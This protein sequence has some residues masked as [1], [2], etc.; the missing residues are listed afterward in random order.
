[1]KP[2]LPLTLAVALSTASAGLAYNAPLTTTSTAV[3]GSSSIGNGQTY[4]GV[5]Y[6]Y[7]SGSLFASA[8]FSQYINAD[9]TM[10]DGATTLGTADVTVD[11]K[12]HALWYLYCDNAN[13]TRGH[14]LRFKASATA[15]SS[16]MKFSPETLGGLIVENAENIQGASNVKL[17]SGGN[18]RQLYIGGAESTGV[19]FTIGA[20][21]EL[22][23]ANIALTSASNK[24]QVS[25]GKTLKFTAS[26]SVTFAADSTTTVSSGGTVD[27][28]TSHALTGSNSRIVL[29]DASTLSNVTLGNGMIISTDTNA[30]GTLNNLTLNG[31]TI[32]FG[33]LSGTV[34]GLSYTGTLTLT[35]GD[36][37]IAGIDST[38]LS[39]GSIYTLLS[40]TGGSGSLTGLTINGAEIAENGSFTMTADSKR[41][42]GSL[43]WS[44]GN[45]QLQDLTL[46]SR[47]LTW[48]GGAT[49]VWSAS[50]SVTG[51]NLD[52]AAGGASSFADGDT[53]NISG[54]ASVVLTVEGSVDP[55]GM[56]ISG[57]AN[58]ILNAGTNGAIT[59]IGSLTVGDS[60]TLTVNMSN[61]YSGGTTVNGGVL[62]ANAANALGTG[63]ITLNRGKLVMGHAE[64]LGTAG[65]V[66][67]GGTLQYG[68]GISTDISG[69][70][71]S[72][73]T[74][75]RIDTNGNNVTWANAVGS[76][77]VKEGAGRLTL[78]TGNLNKGGN[79]TI[80][81]GELAF[82]FTSDITTTITNAGDLTLAGSGTLVKT[83]TGTWTI[84]Q[85]ASSSGE[86]GANAL[87]GNSA[88]TGDVL[89]KEGTL[90]LGNSGN[91]LTAQI[92]SADV[93]G[94]SGKITVNGGATLF[95]KMTQK[96]TINFSKE[97]TLNGNTTL[98]TYD[99]NYNLNGKVRLDGDATI[100]IG[101][102][103][104]VNITRLLEGTGKL[105]L[106]H[107]NTAGILNLGVHADDAGKTGFSGGIEFLADD[108]TVRFAKAQALG[109]GSINFGTTT[110]DTRF[111]EYAGTGTDYETVNNVVTGDGSVKVTSGNLAMTGT[112]TYTG[113]TTVA[114]NANLA[115]KDNGSIDNGTAKIAAKTSGTDAVL[116]NATVSASGI[117][118][119]AGTE[120]GSVSNALITVTQAE[121]A[122]SLANV[123][124]ANSLVDLSKAGT[125]T[126]S[127]VTFSGD[128]KIALTLGNEVGVT[129]STTEN[130]THTFA[131]TQKT[132]E[133]SVSKT[134]SWTGVEAAQ[135][136]LNLNN[137]LLC[138]ADLAGKHSV[139]IWLEGLTLTEPS[140]QLTLADHLKN[141]LK[142]DGA[143]VA[144]DSYTAGSGAAGTS[145]TVV[146]VDFTP[147]VM[148]EPT[149]ATLGLLGL[150]ALLLRRRRRA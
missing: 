137:S 91:E 44:N 45:L 93:L 55:A 29:K 102:D 126:L 85:A 46:L 8:N 124:L 2:H 40:G 118:R 4:S 99:G 104:T 119:T 139:M 30:T 116:T 27:L 110:A 24:L 142:V 59:G 130:L 39:E 26:A 33:N 20:N 6:T 11:G 17:F 112:N 114:Q 140:T 28:T 47:N 31:G 3:A 117:N 148:P 74:S 121:S 128:S 97:I 68:S 41:Y 98:K 138:S 66:F 14:T 84:T 62:H 101:W 38:L 35:A 143:S 12:T 149:T 90:Q 70:I 100:H 56:L 79:L 131:G 63:D 7:L 76:P 5:I 58:L 89:V 43:A 34:S 22:N 78:A 61:T 92:V 54:T 15:I 69:Q 21:T 141:G 135:L 108:M 23:F 145:G 94:S 86:A 87:S 71:A 75:V 144:I 1:M 133:S 81:G 136:M 113:S 107:N 67:K 64:A 18:S 57:N 16:E 103:K 49:G 32:D 10:S 19:V 52:G 111:L 42:S 147:A 60:A 105:K 53:V 82:N 106:N 65:I 109:T 95:F 115:L 72:T 129:T 80:N 146:Y 132:A 51:W 13:S 120:K 127:N 50:N 37:S 25:S 48:G 150:S 88:F 83:G 125:V 122:F 9:G 134:L 96:G 123:D 36:L 73:S 77:L